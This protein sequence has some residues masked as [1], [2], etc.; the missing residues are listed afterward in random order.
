MFFNKVIFHEKK[1]FSTVSNPPKIALK[2][3]DA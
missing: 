3:L 2:F 1:N